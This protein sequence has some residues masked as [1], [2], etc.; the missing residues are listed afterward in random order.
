M[1]AANHN[2]ISGID[3]EILELFVRLAG[4]LNM[5]RSIG[6]LY[7]ALF[8]AP[9]PL[10]MDDLLQRLRLSKGAVSQGL[11][12]LRAFGAVKTVYMPGDRRDHFE[13]EIE[14]RKL[15]AG[16]LREKVRPHL[17]SGQERLEQIESMLNA[18]PGEA[19]AL[20]LERVSRL[21]S[22]QRRAQQ[23]LPFATKIIE[24]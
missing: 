10:T 5:P 1:T 12:M 11:K 21:K 4:M 23:I 24:R 15:A 20:L 9:E 16:F 19:N 17:E 2:G 7:G 3:R 14:L 8:V 22:W 18:R 6:E 13:A